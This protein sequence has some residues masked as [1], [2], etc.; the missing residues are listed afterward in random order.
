MTAW[1]QLASLLTAH[2]CLF[3]DATERRFTAIQSQI[4]AVYPPMWTFKIFAG[5]NTSS[6]VPGVE[7][8]K[9]MLLAFHWTYKTRVLHSVHFDSSCWPE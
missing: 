9:T 3:A 7:V 6:G 2:V 1:P 5:T 8:D 4:Y